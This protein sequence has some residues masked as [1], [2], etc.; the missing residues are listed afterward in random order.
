MWG[1]ECA[2]QTDEPQRRQ[3]WRA[4]RSRPKR[5]SHPRACRMRK[6]APRACCTASRE[7]GPIMRMWVRRLARRLKMPVSRQ[8]MV[9]GRVRH[10]VHSLDRG[11]LLYQQPLRSD[12]LLAQLLPGKKAKLQDRLLAHCITFAA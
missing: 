5:T 6:A 9:D 10:L 8:R 7:V 3:W 1:C 4:A 12:Q 11:P 2:S